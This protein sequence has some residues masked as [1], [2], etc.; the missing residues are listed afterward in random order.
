MNTTDTRP[1]SARS[2]VPDRFD[3]PGATPTPLRGW[4]EDD[5]ERLKARVLRERL[6]AASDPAAQAL[7]RRAGAEA[8]ALAWLTPYPLLVFPALF[9][10]KL[11]SALKV[12][13]FQARV[14]ER[15][16][17]LALAE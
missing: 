14:L 10:E 8:A 13:A 7:V 6:T 15:S 5:L 1:T 12:R 2:G 3:L 9:D 16:S 11:E 17:E 4:R